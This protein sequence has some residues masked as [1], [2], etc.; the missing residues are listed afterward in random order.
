MKR[1][2]IKIFADN[3]LFSFMSAAAFHIKMTLKM[4]AMHML[5]NNMKL[6]MYPGQA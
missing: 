5:T 4:Y 1:I 6:Y 3:G 2:E